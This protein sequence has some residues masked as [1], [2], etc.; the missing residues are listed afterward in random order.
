V[1]VV[2]SRWTLTAGATSPLT[3]AC[4]S[5]S[6]MSKLIVTPSSMTSWSSKGAMGPTFAARTRRHE[7]RAAASLR[8]P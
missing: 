5:S 1:Q 4:G 2:G 8:A 7:S 3:D 6:A